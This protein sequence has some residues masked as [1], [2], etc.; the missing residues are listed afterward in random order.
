MSKIKKLFETPKKAVCSS[1]CAVAL[2]A[3]VG[4]GTMVAAGAI[5]KSSAIGA[6]NAQNFAFADA[7]V[8]PVSAKGVKTSFDFELGQFVYEV[9]FFANGTEYEYLVKSSDG[10]IL[11]KDI[12]IKNQDG[13][14]V[15]GSAEITQ[16]QAKEI[17]L[18]DAG[19][20]ASSVKFIDNHLDVDDGITMYDIEFVSGDTKYEYEINAVNGSVY[21]KS[22]ETV[23]PQN[24]TQAQPTKPTAGN[25][26]KPANQEKTQP[27]KSNENNATA[28]ISLEKAKSIALSNA[29]VSASQVKF[30][31][32]TLEY[33]DGVQVYDIE[34][35]TAEREY[36]YEINAK[37]GAIVDKSIEKLDNVK[38]TQ[39]QP[40]A[41]KSGTYIG[42]DKAKSIAVAKAGLSMADVNFKKAKLDREDGKVVYEIEF[43]NG[44]ME[45]ECT[46]NALDG[47]VM[48]FDSEY[49]D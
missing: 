6:E 28:S 7:G 22:R 14:V 2:L 13:S 31:K 9:D 20:D 5:A 3:T 42:V 11:K 10:T 44:R 23:S 35:N 40:E 18:K 19:V 33:D 36:E 12:E 16:E 47:T 41:E 38:P 46:V 37:N 4:T 32:Q 49:D 26:V 45:Y 17:A 34:F 39:K 8:D 27:S 29:G 48:E 30:V 24:P 25:P 21:S 15:K 43:Y 1:I